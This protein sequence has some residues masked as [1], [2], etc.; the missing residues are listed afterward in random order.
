M[1]RLCDNLL[2]TCNDAD[3]ERD[4]PFE[5]TGPKPLTTGNVTQCAAFSRTFVKIPVIMD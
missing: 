2:S 3:W 5:P 1:L 4:V